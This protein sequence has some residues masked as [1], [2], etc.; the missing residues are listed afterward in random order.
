MHHTYTFLESW[1]IS[2]LNLYETAENRIN[3]K[4]FE[5]AKSDNHV[6]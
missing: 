5:K 2:F 3:I 6:T 1:Q 4:D